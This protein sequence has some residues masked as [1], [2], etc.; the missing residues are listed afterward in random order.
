MYI[1]IHVHIYILSMISLIVPK[2]DMVT[3]VNKLPLEFALISTAHKCLLHQS[4]VC[5]TVS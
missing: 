4:F 5:Q 1:I 3:C 2:R